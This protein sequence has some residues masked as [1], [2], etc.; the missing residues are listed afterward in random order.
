MQLN[1]T[2]QCNQHDQWVIS[3]YVYS[4]YHCSDFSSSG[5]SQPCF[6]IVTSSLIEQP[7][8]RHPVLPEMPYNIQDV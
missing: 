7:N 8:S 5:N 6:R 3:V 2:L 1:C 4:W